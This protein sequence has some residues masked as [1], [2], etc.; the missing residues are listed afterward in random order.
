MALKQP[1]QT[2][3]C[4]SRLSAKISFMCGVDMKRCSTPSVAQ[5]LAMFAFAPSAM[6]P[7]SSV[8]ARIRGVSSA[9]RQSA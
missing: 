3:A 8:A 2:L 1:L 7:L 6:K 9:S 4:R 5:T